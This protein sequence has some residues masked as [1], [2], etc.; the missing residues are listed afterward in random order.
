MSIST[1]ISTA[2]ST[3]KTLAA[4][5]LTAT[6][7]IVPAALPAQAATATTQSA[8]QTTTRAAAFDDRAVVDLLAFGRGPIAEQRP[9]LVRQLGHA[10]ASSAPADL[11]DTL[12]A[13]LREVDPDFTARVTTGAQAK[14]PYRAETALQAF[15]DDVALVAAKYST[16][17]ATPGTRSDA[18]ASSPLTVSPY[19]GKVVGFTNVFVSTQVVIAAAVAASVA[20]VVGALAVIVYQSPSGDTDLIREGLA[21]SL[22]E[23]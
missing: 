2:F 5:A 12:L 22:S 11:T 8:N 21:A 1:A 9:E 18:T 6:L 13:D 14:D 7:A 15:S 10:G 23:L 16:G 19:N 20:A 4:L 3:K 17:S